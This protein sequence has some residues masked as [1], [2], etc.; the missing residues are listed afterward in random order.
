MLTKTS[1]L[2]GLPCLR[3][4]SV[5]V[6]GTMLAQTT[7]LADGGAVQWRK[8]AGGLVITVFAS[9]S[10]LAAGPADISLLVQNSD[11]LDPTLDAEVS[12]ILRA[13][14]SSAEVRAPATRENAQN[15]LLY[16]TPVTL[17]E[18]GKWDLTVGILRN[19]QRMEATG[20]IDVAPAPRSA[21]SYWSYL[22]F[23]P[24]MVLA[25]VI[26]ER[27]IRRRRGAVDPNKTP[28]G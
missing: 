27:L 2:G 23:P 26:R 28:L 19:G 11:G 8:E 5:L 12:L 9:P 13:E 18:S 10:P 22:A 24:L 1:S 25:F 21:S 14:G 17:P 4:F 15:K 7:A 3:L 6:A 20:T 16:A